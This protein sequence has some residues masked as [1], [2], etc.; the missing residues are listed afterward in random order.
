MQNAGHVPRA[1]ARSQQWL[2]PVLVSSD[3]GF[4][5][6][7][8]FTHKNL[9]FTQQTLCNAKCRSVRTDDVYQEPADQPDNSKGPLSVAR[10][11]RG[12]GFTQFHT[13]YVPL[14]NNAGYGKPTFPC[15]S[16]RGL[17]AAN[18]LTLGMAI[19]K[20]SFYLRFIWYTWNVK[21]TTTTTW[22]TSSWLHILQN[23]FTHYFRHGA[24]VTSP[25]RMMLVAVC[26]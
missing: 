16:E 20:S 23:T 12:S 14:G 13:T 22:S 17:S 21:T 11:E 6:N 26:R 24:H 4:Y 15:G 7:L 2:E 3:W 25:L 19:A 10:R 9:R 8:R 18:R 1:A 5:L